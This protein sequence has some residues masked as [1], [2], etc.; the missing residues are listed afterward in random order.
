MQ[1]ESTLSHGCC[2]HA[3][4]DVDTWSGSFL[5]RLSIVLTD[6]KTPREKMEEK[7]QG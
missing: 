1:I 3:G 7:I 4:L 2:N 5:L 6:P